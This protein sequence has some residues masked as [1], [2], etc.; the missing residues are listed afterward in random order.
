MAQFNCFTRDYEQL[1]WFTTFI[2]G[3]I[4]ASKSLL[5]QK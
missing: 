2:N 5:K 1:F 4:S 3:M